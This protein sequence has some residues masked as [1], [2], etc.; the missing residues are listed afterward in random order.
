L[1]AFIVLVLKREVYFYMAIFMGFLFYLLAG[2]RTTYKG[3]SF[4]RGGLAGLWAGITS[5]IIFWIIFGVGLLLLLSQRISA[6]TQAAQRQNTTLPHNEIDRALK[7]IAPII[8][9]HPTTQPS[10]SDVVTFLIA[11]IIVA[12]SFGLLGGVL[13]KLRYK[14][15]LKKGKPV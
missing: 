4:W 13:G 7:A 8:A 6:D 5:T 3:G 15:A 1:A 14:D 2:F 9:N 12:V 10:G 11:G